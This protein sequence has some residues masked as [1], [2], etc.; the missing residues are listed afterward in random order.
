ME[1][2]KE[3]LAY[4]L[5]FSIYSHYYQHSFALFAITLVIIFCARIYSHYYRTHSHCSR[6]LLFNPHI[7]LTRKLIDKP[8][9]AVKRT[10]SARYLI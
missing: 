7:V 3:S 9:G 1:T 2:E 4:N 8:R 6:L 5:V 10:E